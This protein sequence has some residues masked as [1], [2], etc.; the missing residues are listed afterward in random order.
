MAIRDTLRRNAAPFVENDEVVQVAFSAQ[1][2][3][4]YLLL[5]LPLLNS[6]RVVVV[7]NRRILVLRGGKWRL[8]RILGEVRELPRTTIIGPAHGLW[9]RFDALGERLY[10][11]KRFHKDIAAADSSLPPVSA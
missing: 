3:S 1:T 8:T 6:Y 9:Y 2:H 7:T 4:Q 11:H 5:L 10:V